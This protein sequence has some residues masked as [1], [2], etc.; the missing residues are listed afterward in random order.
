MTALGDDIRK[1]GRTTPPIPVLGRKT[2]YLLSL[3][4]DPNGATRQSSGTMGQPTASRKHPAASLGHQDW[5]Q[6]PLC[7]IFSWSGVDA[8]KLHSYVENRFPKR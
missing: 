7:E 4:G 5:E 3:Q 1:L 2:L 8:K 6:H